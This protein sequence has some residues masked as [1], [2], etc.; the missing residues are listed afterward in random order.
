MRIVFVGDV[1]GRSGR[2]ALLEVLPSFRNDL[3]A[4]AVIVNGENAAGGFGI[5]AAIAEEFLAAGVD[6][7]TMGNHVWDQKDLIRAIDGEP[8]IVRPLNMAMGT[9]GRGVHEVRTARGKRLVVMQV[10]GR[11]FTG[12]YDDPFRAV[13]NE[14]AKLSLG[15]NVDAILVDIH[16]ET[17]SEKASLGHHLDGRVSAVVGTH[18]HI[19]TA[20]ARVLAAGTAFITDVGMTG[21]YDSV[22]G[23]VKEYAVQRWLSSLPSQRLAPAMGEATLC[24]VLIDTDDATGLARSIRPI[25][26]GP[27]LEAAWPQI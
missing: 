2:T 21:D 26:R 23:M 16:A 10:I 20:D 3:K 13:A 12:M 1:V 22:I 9:P 24:A 11:L 15:A 25:R 18:T 8:R 14:L 19:P 4:D 27:G 5:T 7:I 6:C 17:T